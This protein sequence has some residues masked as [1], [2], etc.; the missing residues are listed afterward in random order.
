MRITADPSTSP[1]DYEFCHQVRVRFAET[2]AM[3][4]VHHS[5][6]TNTYAPHEVPSIIA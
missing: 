6:G 2:D 1:A 5:A 4:I 3:G